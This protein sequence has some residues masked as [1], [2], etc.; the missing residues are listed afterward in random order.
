MRAVL[1]LQFHSW[2]TEKHWFSPAPRPRHYSRCWGQPKPFSTTANGFKE[3][4]RTC[5]RIQISRFDDFRRGDETAEGCRSSGERSGRINKTIP[6][7][8]CTV[9]ITSILRWRN[10]MEVMERSSLLMKRVAIAVIVNWMSKHFICF[11]TCFQPINQQNEGGIQV[12]SE[13][14]LLFCFLLFLLSPSSI[15]YEHLSSLKRRTSSHWGS[16]CASGLRIVLFIVLSR[17]SHVQN[18]N[19]VVAE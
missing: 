14:F 15:L 17:R 11:K 10:E 16:V 12:Q 3:F 8:Y 6:G 9:G 1:L 18:E 4:S 7:H 5:G 13:N 19:K 2:A